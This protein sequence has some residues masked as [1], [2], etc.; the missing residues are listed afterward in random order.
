MKHACIS[1]DALANGP[2]WK[3]STATRRSEQ[4]ITIQPRLMVNIAEAAIDGAIAGVGLAHVLSYQA[5]PAYSAGKLKLV[6]REF[7]PAPVPVSLVH[8]GQSRMPAKSRRFLEFAVPRM[9]QVLEKLTK[10][11]LP[12]S[13]KPGSSAGAYA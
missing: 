10:K 1:F 6:M 4:R 5:W 3:F 8:A 9:R 12:A 2:A 13:A 11:N 7:D